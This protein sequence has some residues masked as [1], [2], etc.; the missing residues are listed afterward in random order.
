MYDMILIITIIIYVILVKP[1]ISV[2][3]KINLKLYIEIYLKKNTNLINK[4]HT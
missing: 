4:C 1:K 3:Y 2:F